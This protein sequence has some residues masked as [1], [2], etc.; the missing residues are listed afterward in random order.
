MAGVMDQINW[1]YGNDESSDGVDYAVLPE[2][3]GNTRLLREL[4]GGSWVITDGE[5]LHSQTDSEGRVHIIGA[6]AGELLTIG[7]TVRTARGRLLTIEKMEMRCNGQY[8][9]SAAEVKEG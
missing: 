1:N 4:G 2:R 9:V 8:V 6:G 7:S 5:D 3:D